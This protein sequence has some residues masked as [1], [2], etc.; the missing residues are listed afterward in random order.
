MESKHWWQR[1]ICSEIKS[2]IHMLYS[3]IKCK[4]IWKQVFQIFKFQVTWKHILT[5]MTNYDMNS[6]CVQFYNL[7]FCIAVYTICKENSHCKFS[8]EDYQQVNLQKAV[9]K[10][11]LFYKN[12]KSNRHLDIHRLIEQFTKKFQDLND[13]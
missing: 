1:V 8:W 11:L 4:D 6:V 13:H 5:G 12:V 10:N 3:C 9:V 2:T 7:L